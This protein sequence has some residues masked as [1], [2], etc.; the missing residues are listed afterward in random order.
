MVFNWIERFETCNGVLILVKYVKLLTG[1]IYSGLRCRVFNSKFHDFSKIIKWCVGLL[2]LLISQ[3]PNIIWARSILKQGS[4]VTISYLNTHF[5]TTLHT[6]SL[7]T[8]YRAVTYNHHVFMDNL[9]AVE[10]STY[11]LIKLCHFT[12]VLDSTNASH[13]FGTLE[14][15]LCVRLCRRR[16][17]L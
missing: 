17:F 3:T 16:M 9:E 10:F 15:Y 14:F 8:F 11:W 1:T 13:Y 7:F 12:G 4:I 6:I 5:K 2:N